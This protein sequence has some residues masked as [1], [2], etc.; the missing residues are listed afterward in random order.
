MMKNQ[1]GQMEMPASHDCCKKAPKSFGDSALKTNAVSL[2]PAAF[3]A[4]WVSSYELLAPQNAII[5]WFQ[6]PEHSPP[7][8]PPAAITILRI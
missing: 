8:A 1:C 2:H 5:G 7:K 6:R 4:L 3:V